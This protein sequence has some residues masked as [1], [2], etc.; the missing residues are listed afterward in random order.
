[1]CWYILISFGSECPERILPGK[2]RDLLE[3]HGRLILQLEGLKNVKKEKKSR[4]TIPKLETC[5]GNRNGLCVEGHFHT[6]SPE[7][8]GWSWYG[9]CFGAPVLITEECRG[10]T[11]VA[12]SVWIVGPQNSLC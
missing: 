7:C 8:Y 4:L 5:C 6:Q 3:D 12:Q 9:F 2:R 1:M 10:E 11:A